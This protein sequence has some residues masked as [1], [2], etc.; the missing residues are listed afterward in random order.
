MKLD[1][2]VPAV[3]VAQPRHR[4]SVMGGRVHVY[5]AKSDHPVHAYKATLL[6]AAREAYDGPPLQGRVQIDLLFLFPRPQ[7]LIWKK[8]PMPRCE[9]VTKPD[10]DNL[11]KATLDALKGLL[12]VDDCQV[13]GSIDKL[14]AAGDEQPCVLV[15]VQHGEWEMN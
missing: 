4:A 8:R 1:F 11:D 15:S 10:R 9:H 7:R 12:F 2:V 6:H 13:V 14:Y 5:G 3:P